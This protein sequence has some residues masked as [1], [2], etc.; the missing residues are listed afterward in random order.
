MMRPKPLSYMCGK[1]GADQQ[2]RRLHHECEHE[3]EAVRR[4]VGDRADMLDSRVVDQDVGL[5]LQLLQR[6]DVGKVYRPGL[7]ADLL[8]DVLGADV[9]EV[10]DGHDGPT[11]GKLAGACRADAARRRR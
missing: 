1:R 9:I 5:Q 7:S 8:R 4:E 2:E 11:R 3:P 6:A 10:R